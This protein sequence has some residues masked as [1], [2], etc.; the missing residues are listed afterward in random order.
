MNCKKCG[1]SNLEKRTAAVPGQLRGERFAVTMPALVCPKC[2][3]VTVDGADLAEY[4]RRVADA[5][6]SK[7]GLLTSEEIRSRRLRLDMSQAKF[8]DYLG[9]GVASLKRWE[10]GKVQDGSSDKLIRLRSDEDEAS[11]NLDRIR[12]IRPPFLGA[13]RQPIRDS[14][15]RQKLSRRLN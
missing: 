2:R 6:R 9:V 12:D 14:R 4:M 8:A 5:Y 10:M 13:W 1:K 11:R 3:Y 15:P 7:H